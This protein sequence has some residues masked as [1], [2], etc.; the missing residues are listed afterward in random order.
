MADYTYT[1]LTREGKSVSGSI[2]APSEGELRVL[3]RSQG[4]RPT[5]LSLKGKAPAKMGGLFGASKGG[6]R[7]PSEVMLI[8]VRQLY[9]LVGA[10]I[11]LIQALETLAEQAAHPGMKFILNDV[12]SRVSAGAYFWESISIYPNAFGKL[13]ISLIRAGESAGAMDE[14]LARLTTYIEDAERL[15]KLLKGA[16]IYPIA[17]V[18]V[19]IGVI[20]SMMIFVIPKFE[21]LLTSSGQKLPALTQGVIDVSH[22]MVNHIVIITLGTVGGVMGLM[23][24]IRTPEGRAFVDR[25]FFKAPVFGN[26]M[27]KGGIARFSRTMQTLLSSGVALLDA[28][29]ICKQTVDNVVIEEQVAKIRVQ[30]EQGNRLGT[31]LNSMPIFP[32]MAV[33]MISVGES[34]GSLDQMLEKV[35]DFYEAEVENAISGLT[36]LIEPFMLVF[37]GGAV[38]T[39]L[40]AMYLPI[41]QMGA[42]AS[43]E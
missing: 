34:S 43:S 24:F 4:I 13:F 11:P 40:I 16:M 17:V 38:G 41:F 32:K 33:Q 39:L 27:Q 31:V 19:G 26:I 37:L 1:G 2:S 6:P 28:I 5:K 20:A 9:V 23:N 22:F 21:E 10:G 25:A 36:K 8:F 35:A 42:G 29:D 14:M 7:V 3:L 18:C 30:I 12:K 15:R